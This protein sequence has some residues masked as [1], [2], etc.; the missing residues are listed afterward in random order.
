MFVWSNLEKNQLLVSP[1]NANL[2]L[3]TGWLNDNLSFSLSFSPLSSQIISNKSPYENGLYFIRFQCSE[4]SMNIPFISDF[5]CVYFVDLIWQ[6][7]FGRNNMY[8]HYK[9]DYISA[10]KRRKQKVKKM[11][12]Y[13]LQFSFLVSFY[14]LTE[15]KLVVMLFLL[16]LSSICNSVS[17]IVCLNLNALYPFGFALTC[18][19]FLVTYLK[20]IGFG[21]ILV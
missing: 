18:F 13:F 1:C 5:V 10:L 21:G 14:F 19:I 9:D 11:S 12:Q 16:S 4:F 8:I 3:P 7:H 20:T 6:L 2:Q 17:N 15:Q